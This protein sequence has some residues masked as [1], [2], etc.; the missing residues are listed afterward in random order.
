MKKFTRLILILLVLAGLLGSAEYAIRHKLIVINDYF[1]KEDD[2]IG[3][4]LS[5]YQGEVDMDVLTS[6]GIRF[7]II[8]A[9]EGSGHTDPYF[10]V[11]WENVKKTGVLAGAYHFFSFDS[12]AVTQAEQYIRTVGSLKG[13]MRPIVDIEFYADKKENPPTAEEVRREVGIFLELLENEYH[14]KPMIYASEEVYKKYLSGYFDEYPRWVISM[15][16]PAF[17]QNG[18]DWLLWQYSD[19]GEL[20]GFNGREKYIDLNVLNRNASLDDLKSGY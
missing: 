11:N 12:S 1:V 18:S 6:Q 17:V 9:T 5:E 16:Y 14:V 2:T 15:Y 19:R 8:K 4:D 10:A 20:S 7:V 3:V 13:M